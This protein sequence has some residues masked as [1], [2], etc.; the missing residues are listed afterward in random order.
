MKFPH[1]LGIIGGMGPLATAD[2]LHRLVSMTPGEKDQDHPRILV[3][4]NPEIPDRTLA[5][6]GKG[7]SPVPAILE[8]AGNLM[9][10]GA[11]LL[12]MPCVTAHHY[13]EEIQ[14]ALAVPVIHMIQEV[15]GRYEDDFL[16]RRAG[17]LATDG[18]LEAKIFQIHLPSDR[19]LTPDDATQR[20][21]VMKALYGKTSVKGGETM[22]AKCLLLQAAGRLIR[23]G[24]EILVA[25]CTEVSF[26]L[27]P[28]DLDVPLLD[29]V[30]VLCRACL[31]R[32]TR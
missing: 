16:G 14:A 17:L 32:L 20:D 23:E 11:D 6:L 10:A 13:H 9:C 18:T 15:A 28:G 27:D 7:P 5:I 30:E 19:I 12:A 1:T 25:G 3:D 24:A 8:T 4:S 31:D 29:T 22:Q 21:L 2:F 26:L